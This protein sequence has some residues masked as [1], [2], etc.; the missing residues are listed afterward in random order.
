MELKEF[1][2]QHCTVEH[3]TEA[4]FGSLLIELF[5]PSTAV[6]HMIEIATVNANIFMFMKIS[7]RVIFD[8]RS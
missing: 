1:I 2:S 7:L 4:W 8:K 5:V 3:F 6:P